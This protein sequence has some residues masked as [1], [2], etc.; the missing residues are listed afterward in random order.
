MKVTIKRKNGNTITYNRAYE[1]FGRGKH[2]E[3]FVVLY[4]D[5]LDHRYETIATDHDFKEAYTHFIELLL[6]DDSELY[7][8]RILE[9]NTV[10]EDGAD[11]K[12]LREEGKMNVLW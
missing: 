1:V 12:R 3:K 5:E 2:D 9:G 11:I 4:P 7:N 8:Y 10:I 6:N